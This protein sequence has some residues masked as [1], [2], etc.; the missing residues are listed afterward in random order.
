MQRPVKLTLSIPI[1]ADQQ[2]G[3]LQSG[4][5][6]HSSIPVRFVNNAASLEAMVSVIPMQA[7]GSNVAQSTRS[8]IQLLL[9]GVCLGVYLLYLLLLARI[10]A[11]DPL[12]PLRNVRAAALGVG[13][14]FLLC[15]ASTA[16]FGYWLRKQRGASRS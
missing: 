16:V 7:S 13:L 9:I 6:L 4:L 1:S 15:L 8:G 14:N 2:T 3:L 5:W 12:A 11:D 10:V